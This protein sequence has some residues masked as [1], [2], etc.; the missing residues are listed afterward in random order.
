[1]LT[2]FSSTSATQVGIYYGPDAMC[3]GVPSGRM[4]RFSGANLRTWSL[5]N[6]CVAVQCKEDG[7]LSVM[8]QKV[9]SSEWQEF[10]CPENGFVELGVGEGY[11]SDVRF[12]LPLLFSKLDGQGWGLL[13]RWR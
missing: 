11:S 3:I 2:R 9:T 7:K 4:S 12:V 1:M 6:A 5:D 13:L 10:D 8:I